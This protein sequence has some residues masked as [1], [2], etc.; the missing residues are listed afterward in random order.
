MNARGQTVDS[1]LDRVAANLAA[2]HLDLGWQFL[3]QFGKARWLNLCGYVVR[4]EALLRVG[5]RNVAT[6]EDMWLH[7]DLLQEPRTRI[8][9][10][11]DSKQF[12]SYRLHASQHTRAT[13]AGSGWAHVTESVSVVRASI[14]A[15]IIARYDCGDV[16]GL[17]MCQLL[18]ATDVIIGVRANARA[19]DVTPLHSHAEQWTKQNLE[20]RESSYR[21]ALAFTGGVIPRLTYEVLALEDPGAVELGFK[22]T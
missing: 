3:S 9:F 20:L 16:T 6:S 10:L 7:R 12:G 1:P 18:A 13:K 4:T 11:G 5:F 14:Q 22:A 21:S 17:E 2:G 15:L 19:R 8:A